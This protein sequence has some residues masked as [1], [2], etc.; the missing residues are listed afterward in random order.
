MRE[1]T[2]SASSICRAQRRVRGWARGL[3]NC[4]GLAEEAKNSRG[5]RGLGRGCGKELL[6]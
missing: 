2:L 6:V 1:A 4:R 3:W 5:C